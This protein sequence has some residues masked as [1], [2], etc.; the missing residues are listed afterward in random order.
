M[1]L[2]DRKVIAIILDECDK[3]EERC[4]GYRDAIR[5]TVADILWYERQHRTAAIDIQKKINQKCES[6]AEFL[7]LNDV[8]AGKE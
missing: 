7:V 3:L 8:P 5:E 4:T 1:P 2:S 6:A